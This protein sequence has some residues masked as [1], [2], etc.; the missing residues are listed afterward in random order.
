MPTTMS[1]IETGPESQTA[2][3]QTKGVMKSGQP[4]VY[5]EKSL[6]DDSKT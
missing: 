2:R 3:N 5:W 6:P 1:P 4:G